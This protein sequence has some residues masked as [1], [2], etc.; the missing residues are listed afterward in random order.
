[1]K[2]PFTLKVQELIENIAKI[3][4]EVELPAFAVKNALE[5]VYKQVSDIEHQEI[6][7][8]NKQLDQLPKEKDNNEI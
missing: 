5:N 7:E 6:M 2:K 4:N 8:Y 1:M 3:I